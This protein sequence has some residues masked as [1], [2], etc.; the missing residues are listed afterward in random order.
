MRN[1]PYDYHQHWQVC[2]NCKASWHPAEKD[3]DCV[4]CE[5]CNKL[6][7]PDQM[8]QVLCFECRLDLA[9]EVTID[10]D[11]GEGFCQEI[12][13]PDTVTDTDYECHFSTPDTL[14]VSLSG[15]KKGEG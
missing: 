9:G 7:S 11:A 5:S 6:R 1:I 3:C 8:T 4:V 14:V 15:K 10:Y 2:P 13:L 12:Q